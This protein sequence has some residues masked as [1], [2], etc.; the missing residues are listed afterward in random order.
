[1]CVQR[2]LIQSTK[3]LLGCLRSIGGAFL[4]QLLNERG[5]M[6][7]HRWPM[8]GDVVRFR[9]RVRGQELLSGA[10]LEGRAA[11]ENLV[12]D[13][14]EGGEVG[15]AVDGVARGLFRRHVGGRA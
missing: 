14:T 8:A 15:S 10:P 5:E 1:A 6:S 4:E 11:S 2:L 12:R 7:R 13:D 3:D 9:R